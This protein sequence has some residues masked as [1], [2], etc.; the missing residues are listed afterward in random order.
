MNKR[1][2]LVA[3]GHWRPLVDAL[4]P[5][6]GEHDVAS[7]L[8]GQ[9]SYNIYEAF[10]HAQREREGYADLLDYTQSGGIDVAKMLRAVE[11][12][13]EVR[14]LIEG[15]PIQLQM[16]Y[17]L[18]RTIEFAHQQQPFSAIITTCTYDPIGLSVLLEAKHQ[19]ISCV[20]VHH[21]CHA[22]TPEDAWY[23]RDYLADVICCPGERDAQW[24]R[25][26]LGEDLWRQ[27][28][29]RIEVT[30]QPLWDCYAT[31]QRVSHEKPCVLWAAESG[32]NPGQTPA[33][34]RS[35]DV[36]ERAWQAFLHAMK[37]IE[38]PCEIVLKV[39]TGED[40]EV[41]QRWMNDLHD[42]E[43]EH[44]VTVSSQLS[45]DVLSRV[46]VVVCQDSSIGVEALCLGIPVISITR[47]GG[48]LFKLP[49][50]VLS[51]KHELSGYLHR[52]IKKALRGDSVTPEAAYYNRGIDGSAMARVVQVISDVAGI[53]G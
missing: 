53:A 36:P 16:A 4:I 43:L 42:W 25:R 7:L 38:T 52:E 11:A 27:P 18:R 21:G 44:E 30:G 2:L 50:P 47:E 20:Y 17:T 22:V 41:I 24:W 8:G 49:V 51:G 1:V 15:L 13:A 48:E 12:P 37:E 9:P 6:F 10:Q 3:P 46:D 32:A 45:W 28:V 35:R 5:V 33:I 29:P 23:C 31:T 14:E 26:C 39:R 34:Y 19:G 40:P